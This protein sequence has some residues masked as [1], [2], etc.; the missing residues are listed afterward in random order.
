MLPIPSIWEAKSLGH[1]L[2]VWA[3][4]FAFIPFRRTR[5]SRGSQTSCSDV[6][7]FLVRSLAE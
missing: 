4:T 2:R 5:C 7:Q 1:G 3:E 6:E